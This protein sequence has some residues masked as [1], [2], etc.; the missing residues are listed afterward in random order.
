MTEN[1]NAKKTPREK[2]TTIT[3]TVAECGEFHD[4]G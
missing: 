2:L 1:R 3:F 4:F